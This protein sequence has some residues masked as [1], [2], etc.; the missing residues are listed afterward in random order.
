[1]KFVFRPKRLDAL[2]ISKRHSRPSI[3]KETESKYFENTRDIEKT[4]RKKI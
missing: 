2:L 4:S 1:M 3:K